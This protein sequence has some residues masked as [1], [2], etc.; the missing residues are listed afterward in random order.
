MRTSQVLSLSDAGVVPRKLVI[1]G[2]THYFEYI[3]AL[4]N[5]NIA[6]PNGSATSTSTYIVHTRNNASRH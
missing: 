3:I 5:G 4:P 6:L 1:N 2:V